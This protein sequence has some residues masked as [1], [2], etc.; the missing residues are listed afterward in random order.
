MKIIPAWGCVYMGRSAVTTLTCVIRCLLHFICKHATRHSNQHAIIKFLSKQYTLVIISWVYWWKKCSD[1]YI[2]VF[3]VC[4]WNKQCILSN[5]NILLKI[6]ACSHDS[7]AR[8]YEYLCVRARISVSTNMHLHYIMSYMT[9]YGDIDL[10]RNWLRWWPVARWYRDVAWTNV[11]LSLISEVQWHSLET[12]RGGC[13][14][15]K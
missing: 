5:H 2:T 9:P 11:D 8:I 10:D 13:I 15:Y 4:V 7:I 3:W 6:W 12:G 1:G 14:H